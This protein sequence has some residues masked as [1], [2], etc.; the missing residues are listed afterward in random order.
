MASARQPSG[1]DS[2]LGQEGS[3]SPPASRTS[4]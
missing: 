4:C 3:A 2:Q 1:N